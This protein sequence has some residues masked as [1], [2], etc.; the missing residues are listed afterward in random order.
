MFLSSVF[1]ILWLFLLVIVFW[2]VGA[3][4]RLA[5]LRASFLQAF[6][7]LDM[8]LVQLLAWLDE[9]V[10]ARAT[11]SAA[12]PA[13]AAQCL[14]AMARA[15]TQPLHAASTVALQDAL[16]VLEAAWMTEISQMQLSPVSATPA[17]ATPWLQRWEQYQVHNAQAQQDLRLAATQY[18]A[19]IAQFPAQLLASLL[20]FKS[21]RTL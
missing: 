3:Y 11:T 17:H 12:L 8:H 5:R 20:G 14:Q 6:A 4:H 19:A 16:Q 7:R 13:A 1:W 2:T 9:Y 15:R 18:N 21:A 10:A